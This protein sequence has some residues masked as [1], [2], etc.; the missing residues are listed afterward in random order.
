MAKQLE[1]DAALLGVLQQRG[2]QSVAQ[3]MAA[4]QVT[5]TAVR[6][7]LTRLL[8][9]GEVERTAERTSR[10]RPVHRYQLTAKGRRRGGNNF[11]DL[12]M[13]LWQEVRDIPD[14]NIRRGLLSRLSGQLSALYS[15]QI[16]GS[17]LS[18]RMESLVELFRDRR[19]PLEVEKSADL[20]LLKVTA[21]PYPGLAEQDRGVCS[22]E[23]MMF[24][25]LLGEDVT[26]SE[27]RLDGHACCTFQPRGTAPDALPEAMITH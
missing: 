2:A 11:G 8:Q 5:A 25:E 26:L 24:S 12:A 7:R 4:L 1:S 16:G 20:P 15:P 9:S 18:E 6:Q 17:T 10:G 3:L 22:M 14:A 19:I 23:R 21:C 27:C 13:A